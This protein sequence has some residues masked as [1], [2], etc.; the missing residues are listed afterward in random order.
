MAP[1]DAI[2]VKLSNIVSKIARTTVKISAGFLKFPIF[3]KDGTCFILL[4]IPNNLEEEK[5]LAI[6]PEN[7]AMI[8]SKMVIQ[9]PQTPK[10]GFAAAAKA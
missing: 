6:T 9:E 3:A 5:T 1:I 8:A 10:T 7:V 2:R 4:N